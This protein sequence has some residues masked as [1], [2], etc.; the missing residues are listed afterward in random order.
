MT[1]GFSFRVDPTANTIPYA[2]ITDDIR[3]NRGFVDLRGHPD[4]AIGEIIGGS[5]REERLASAVPQ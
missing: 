3:R 1:F 2:P 5:Q 4:K